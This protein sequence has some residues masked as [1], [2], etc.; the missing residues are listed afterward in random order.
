[1][2]SLFFKLHTSCE[3]NISVQIFF[4]SCIMKS[5][6][7]TKLLKYYKLRFLNIQAMLAT[8]VSCILWFVKNVKK[9]VNV[10]CLPMEH[11][12]VHKNSFRSLR[13]FQDR[14]GIWKCWFL[15]R[16]ENWSTRKKT[17]RS[18]VENQQQTQPTYDAGS[19][20]RTQATLMGGKRCHGHR[21]VYFRNFSLLLCSV[22]F[23]IHVQE[24]REKKLRKTLT[25]VL[26]QQN[27][28]G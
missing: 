18:R 28:W 12:G 6:H 3:N 1:M 14:I 9:N 26:W 11:Q 27:I 24:L 23:Q 16:G 8:K 22:W 7:Q 25:R 21:C 13:A 2:W 20:N 15:R 5:M 17:S 10:I 4:G 19:G